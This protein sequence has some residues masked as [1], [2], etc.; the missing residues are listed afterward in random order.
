[1]LLAGGDAGQRRHETPSTR[2]RYQGAGGC[3][4]ATGLE[5]GRRC[6]DR[7]VRSRSIRRPPRRRASRGGPRD[8]CS[9]TRIGGGTALL[10]AYQWGPGLSTS[11]LTP[12]PAPGGGGIQGVG[13]WSPC[14]EFL[15]GGCGGGV[16]R[17]PRWRVLAHVKRRHREML[18]GSPMTECRVWM[19]GEANALWDW[20][21][22]ASNA[23]FN[24]TP[25]RTLPWP[26]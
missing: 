1:M 9:L 19:L 23:C 14:L 12:P 26:P 15:A 11:H 3:Q 18:L 5:M 7:E 21:A 10:I 22:R 6:V 17:R 4:G 13:C 16:G 25:V 8:C 24:C 20:K 2:P